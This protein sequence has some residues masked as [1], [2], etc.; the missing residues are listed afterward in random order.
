MKLIETNA[1]DEIETMCESFKDIV[2]NYGPE[3]D[4]VK[5]R[6]MDNSDFE[7]L[8]S[9]IEKENIGKNQIKNLFLQQC[10]EN[11]DLS[12]EILEVLKIKLR[13]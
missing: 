8:I 6:G 12:N 1:R 2:K 4:Q 9:K 11:Y 13:S 5:M 3:K 10:V 7:N